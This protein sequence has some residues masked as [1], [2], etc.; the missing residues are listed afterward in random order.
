MKLRVRFCLGISAL[1]LASSALAEPQ[2]LYR[3]GDA[4]I[5]ARVK[6]LLGRMTLE[7]KVAQLQ[8]NSG[9]PAAPGVAVGPNPAAGLIKKGQID[10]AVAHR[11][12]G[13]G[14][15][16]FSTLGF[17]ASSALDQVNQYNLIQNWLLKN[18]RLGIPTIFVGEALH[19]ATVKGGVQFP[20]ALALG[21]TWDPNLI[22]QMMAVAAKEERAGGASL[23]YSPVFD[24]ARDPRYGR[25]EE[26]YSEDPYLAG[27]MGVAA[28]EGLQGTG[29]LIDQDHV[30]ATAKHFVHGQ[31]ENGTN[32]GPNDVSER[33]M[34]EVF[35]PPFER[36][37]KVGHI[38][39]I[40]PSYNENSGGVPS[41]VNRWL[42]RNV[43]RKEWGFTG[44]TTSDWF[45]ISELHTKH[46][47][48]VDDADAGVQAFNAGVDMENPNPVGYAR[49]AEAV[50]SG[51]VS[52]HD[53]DAAVGRILALKFRAGLFDHPLTNVSRT[54]T[55]IGSTAS[56]PLARKT[57]D[58][59][60]VLLKNDGKLL[61]LD[62]TKIQ[63]LAVIGPNADKVR[64]GGY[65]GEPAYF[66]TVLDG[67]RKRLG[68]KVQVSYAVNRRPSLTPDRRSILTR[69]APAFAVARRRSAEPSRSAAR[70]RRAHPR[71]GLIRNDS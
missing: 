12:I 3:H 55:D 26:M 63:T 14:I 40:M 21:S 59:A 24:L 52:R 54:R 50:R 61:P 2:P 15:G 41:S 23:V 16:S 33:T 58:E 70:S 20:Q 44:I 30:I 27:E 10:E 64:L 62:A 60:M 6:D 36:A 18:T 48:A 9:L 5:P 66:V 22:R 68:D 49:L 25:V 67:V 34:R 43:L 39:A 47:V 29:P 17:G 37:V 51:K 11:T 57:A 65:S 28:V 4:P 42:L 56:I 13:Q 32:V 69:L 1:T 46:H 8:S 35:L 53:L 45:A 7:E 31:P 71:R 38:G 19:G